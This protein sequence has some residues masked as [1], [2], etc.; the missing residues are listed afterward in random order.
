MELLFI[1]Q[2]LLSYSF[3]G[4]GLKYVDQAYDINAFSKKTAII[5]AIITAII[6][7]YISIIDVYSAMIFISL[8]IGMI[9]IKSVD[10]IAFI[11]GALIVGILFLVFGNIASFSWFLF[12][13]LLLSHSIEEI[14]S[15][16]DEKK[17]FKGIKHFLMHYGVQIKSVI[18][19]LVIFGYL[20]LIYFVAFFLLDMFYLIVE[21]YSLKKVRLS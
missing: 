19:I 18:L 13:I 15:E 6:M 5:V 3:I 21:W 8:V 12:L 14:I 20:N 7:S 11:S 16:H 9:I 17:G 4:F 1:F 2:I 10:N